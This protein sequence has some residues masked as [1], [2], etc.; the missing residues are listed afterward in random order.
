VY[1]LGVAIAVL[2]TGK[3]PEALQNNDGSWNLRDSCAIS[4]QFEQILNFALVE[5]SVY[6]YANARQ[7]LMALVPNLQVPTASAFHSANT[8][9]MVNQQSIPSSSIPWGLALAICAIAIV[10]LSALGFSISRFLRDRNNPAISAS[11]PNSA[12][13]PDIS[14][15]AAISTTATSSLFPIPIK[16]SNALSTDANSINSNAIVVSKERVNFDIGSTKAYLRSNVSSSEKRQYIL[17][18]GRG[19][20]FNASLFQGEANVRLIAPDGAIVSSGVNKLSAILPASGDY[21]VEI[22]SFESINF[23]LQIEVL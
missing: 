8:T 7:M 5:N 11:T 4:E 14:L 23:N 10:L 2:L 9:T 19:Q 20:R 17:N 18:C 3:S 12:P 21:T 15:P 22:S 16:S 1:A 13:S 6:R